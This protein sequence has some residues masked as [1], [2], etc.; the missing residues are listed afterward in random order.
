[1][2]L[3]QKLTELA[4]KYEVPGA[5]AGVLSGD[6]TD[7]AVYG[8]TN[9]DHPLPVDESTLFQFG[10]TGK[11]FTATALMVLVEQGLVD[12]NAPVRTYVPELALKD[13]DVAAK[14]TV[15][16]L[17]NHTAGWTGDSIADTGDGDDCVARY[18]ASMVDFDQV[19]PLGSQVSYNNA[20]LIL[21][22]HV[23]A[24][25]TGK[26]YEQAV[27]DLVLEPMG[28]NATYGFGKEI[29]QLRFSSGHVKPEGGEVAVSKPWGLPRSGAAAG[30]W[31]ATIGD[32][33]AWA[34]FHL[35]LSE[36]K[37]ISDESRLLMQQPT[38]AMPG[39][40]L[41]DA[42]GI[43]WLLE[44]LGGVL[45]VGHGGSTIGQLS[46]FAMVPEKQFAFVCMT[47]LA[48]G[49]AELYRDLKAWALEEYAGITTAEPE[50]AELSPEELAAFEGTYDTSV[51]NAVLEARDGL[52]VAT[53][54]ITD[55]TL[56]AEGDK[57][58]QPE[59]ALAL[60]VGAGDRYVVA[61]G[62]AKGMRGYFFRGDDGAVAGVNFSGRDMTKR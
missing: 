17:L 9:L 15:L 24:K 14:V 35:G 16:Q 55:L 49:G 58:V 29:M 12:L 18:V 31:T 48:P 62:E 34:R 2:T 6:T 10:S 44:D 30:G 38:F 40:A 11:T 21:A 26:T 3:Q 32:Q 5:V 57:P 19:S 37:V 8:V 1:M 36:H 41:G 52:L 56:M 59:I 43:S 54:T 13:E 60:V 51:A 53:V 25:V 39:S 33:L 47:N 4:Q 50:L 20:S 61:D 45:Q 22:G 23:I 28:L 46:E 42:V 7:V 27:R